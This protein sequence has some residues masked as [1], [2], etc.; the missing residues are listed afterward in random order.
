[1]GY[2]EVR[3]AIRD[4]L[5]S[6]IEAVD[7]RIYNGWTAPGTTAKPYIVV[8]SAGEVPST[9]NSRRGWMRFDVLVIG[10]EGDTLSIDPIAD[11]VVAALDGESVTLGSSVMRP[12]HKR[13]SRID[14]WIA[15][16]NGSA[17]RLQFWIPA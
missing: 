4:H 9:N 7:E 5:V 13:D 17:V 8:T 12:E 3:K 11:A 1:M 6:A 15:E 10:N 2:A 14:L 16:V